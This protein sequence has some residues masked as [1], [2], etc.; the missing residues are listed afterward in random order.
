MVQLFGSIRRVLDHLADDGVINPLYDTDLAIELDR[1]KPS[2]QPRLPRYQSAL[3]GLVVDLRVSV[4]DLLCRLNTEDELIYSPQ[5]SLLLDQDLPD[6]SRNFLLSYA[7]SQI[8]LLLTVERMLLAP[9]RRHL[10]MDAI[11]QWCAKPEDSG[12]ASYAE[13]VS[14]LLPIYSRTTQLLQD[15]LDIAL[16][17]YNEIDAFS[18]DQKREFLQCQQLVEQ[19]LNAL[20]NRI[21]QGHLDQS[22]KYLEMC[23]VGWGYTIKELGSLL[24][25]DRLQFETTDK[26]VVPATTVSLSFHPNLIRVVVYLSTY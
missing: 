10:W 1:T 18:G 22:L 20:N 14:I 26:N 25:A 24:Q 7:S 16:G 5:T 4:Q 2:W 9:P 15:V 8:D 3:A 13:L 11:S 19:T 12:D 6:I 17:D 21:K 23:C